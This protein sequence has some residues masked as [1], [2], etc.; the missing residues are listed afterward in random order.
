MH[1]DAVS[2]P[3]IGFF[4]HAASVQPS[5]YT[6]TYSTASKTVPNATASNPPPGGTGAMAGAYDTAAHRDAMMPSL[7]NNIAEVLAL[8]KVVN[9]IIDHLQSMGL[10]L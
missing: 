6:Q 5:A 8:K 10:V 4:G 3:K 7:T 1:F 2:E 9:A